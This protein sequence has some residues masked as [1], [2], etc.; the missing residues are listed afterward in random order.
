MPRAV[1]SSAAACA[2]PSSDHQLLGWPLK[3]VMRLRQANDQV[4]RIEKPGTAEQRIFLYTPGTGW[5]ACSPP[6]RPGV[7]HLD[8]APP[9]P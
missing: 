3:K 8:C 9:R 5:K 4:Y 1:R 7:R 2:R 6:E